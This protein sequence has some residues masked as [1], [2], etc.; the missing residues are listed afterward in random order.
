MGRFFIY[1]WGKKELNISKEMGHT[2]CVK[3]WHFIFSKMFR[4]R[5]RAFGHQLLK[6]MFTKK[7]ECK[8]LIHGNVQFMQM[9]S[10][11]VCKATVCARF[12]RQ[13]KRLRT[14]MMNPGGGKSLKSRNVHGMFTAIASPVQTYLYEEDLQYS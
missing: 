7:M 6:L 11:L 5:S 4:I 13:W 12:T 9:Y 2:W 3:K 14:E 1:F 10:R 8:V